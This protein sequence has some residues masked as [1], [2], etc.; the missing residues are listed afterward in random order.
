M[1][2]FRAVPYAKALLAVVQKE[3]R[4]RTEV[5]VEE[6]DGVAA[7]LKAVPEFHEV[8]VTPMV[9]VETKTKILD[10]VL[11]ALEIGEPTR[12]F[13]HV[14]QHHYR[15][16][17]MADI[18]TAFRELVDQSLGR[19]RARVETAI[20]LDEGSRRRLV[21]A[22]S[23]FEGATV[24]ADFEANRDLLGGFKMQVGSRVFDGSLAGELDRLS[25]EIEIEQG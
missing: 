25:K 14:V 3:D 20:E 9:S 23:A 11:D 4:D 5:V 21:D 8:L 19:T 22:I 7:A 2:R 6:L 17:H 1:G 12:R 18:A 24:V 15:M 16:Q 13:L 10:T